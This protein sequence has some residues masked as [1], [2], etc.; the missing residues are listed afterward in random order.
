MKNYKKILDK[1]ERLAWKKLK[2]EKTGH[3]YWYAYRVA[4]TAKLI[5]KKE[6]ANVQ[7]TELAAWLH[8]IEANPDKD[9]EVRSAEYARKLLS[10]LNIDKEIALD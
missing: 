6:K 5:A 10:N 1:V 4:Q 8:D 2:N 3:G 9:H 7:I